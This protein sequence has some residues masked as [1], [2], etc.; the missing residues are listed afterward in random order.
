MNA[1]GHSQDNPTGDNEESGYT[2]MTSETRDVR[3]DSPY[4]DLYQELHTKDQ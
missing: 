4:T 1:S 3:R 2:S